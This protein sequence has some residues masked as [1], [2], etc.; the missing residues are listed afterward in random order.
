MMRRVLQTLVLV[1]ASFSLVAATPATPPT[2]EDG[3]RLAVPPYAY[4]FP[5]DH[6]AHPEFRI[7]WWY[8]TGHLRAGSR[9]FG[10]EQT[11]FRLGIPGVARSTSAGETSTPLACAVF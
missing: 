3:F 5:A 7:E 8:Y 4:V 10:Y 1:L 6:A 9:R 2:D 11:F